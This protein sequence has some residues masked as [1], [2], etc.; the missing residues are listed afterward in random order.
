MII[1]LLNSSSEVVWKVSSEASPGNCTVVQNKRIKIF[2]NK[3]T[4]KSSFGS[5]RY[6]IYIHRTES[7]ERY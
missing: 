5:I 4:F 7:T 1:E 3:V 2:D 6:V